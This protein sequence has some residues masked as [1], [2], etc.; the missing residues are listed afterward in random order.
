MVKNGKARHSI[1]LEEMRW[2][3]GELLHYNLIPDWMQ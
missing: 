1:I 2:A 3:V